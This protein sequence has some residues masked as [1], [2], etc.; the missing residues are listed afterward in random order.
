M[1]QTKK[2][3]LFITKSK[4]RIVNVTLGRNPKEDIIANLGWTPDNLS[5]ILLQSKKNIKEPI[6]ILLSEDFVYTVN[7][8]LSSLPLSR[9]DIKIKAQ[10][11][12][13]ENLDETLWDFREVGLPTKIQV[14][15]VNKALLDTLK[16][17]LARAGIRIE[18]IEPVSLSLARVSR[19]EDKTKVF[20]YKDNGNVL[21]IAAQKGIVLAT[22]KSD[23]ATERLTD[24]NLEAITQFIR[25]TKDQFG[26]EIKDV[27]FCGNTL[28]IDLAKFQNT[29]FNAAIQNINPVISLAYKEDLRGR[30]EEVLNLELLKGVEARPPSRWVGILIAPMLIIIIAIAAGFLVFQ[31]QRRTDQNTTKP[32]Q[33]GLTPTQTVV[34]PR[35]M[36]LTPTATESAQVDFSD[37]SIRILNGSGRAGEAARLEAIL[38]DNGFNVIEIGN[39]NSS[40]YEKTEVYHK[41]EVPQ[42]LILGLDKI[43]NTLYDFSISANLEE[44]SESDILIIIGSAIK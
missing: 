24:L 14:V 32:S 15:A 40:N 4:I 31:A 36:R 16:R 39:A 8:T 20:V 44:D 7:L 42:S 35:Q 28:G 9:E 5:E 37:Y 27:I 26:I 12:I 29:D 23:L 13:P 6:R 33:T 30:D 10:E 34:T 19:K 22:A 2:T 38:E 11:L 21:V 17:S 3:I 25:F 41:E 43:L 1:L 18:A